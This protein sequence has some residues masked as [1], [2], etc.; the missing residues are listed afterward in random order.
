MHPA[1]RRKSGAGPYMHVW[2]GS[3]RAARARLRNR[4]SAVMRRQ[5][6]AR[7]LARSPGPA[8]ERECGERR[9]CCRSAV[10]G[11]LRVRILRNGHSMRH[12]AAPARGRCGRSRAGSRRRGR[13]GARVRQRPG[14][15]RSRAPTEE[16]GRRQRPGSDRGRAPTEAGRRQKRPGRAARAR[17]RKGR[18][19]RER[20]AAVVGAP[21]SLSG[22][23]ADL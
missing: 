22:R 3:W 19:R 1:L 15:D 18:V 23:T 21:G 9:N 4:P 16:A 6:P 11:G 17:L 7:L 13:R 8:A 5:E 12:Q 10:M 20:D 2:P 14:A